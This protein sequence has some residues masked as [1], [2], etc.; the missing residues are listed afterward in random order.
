MIFQIYF[1]Q[2]LQ[3]VAQMSTILN[4]RKCSR[5]VSNHVQKEHKHELSIF[6]DI[7]VLDPRNQDDQDEH[8]V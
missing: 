8:E 4:S 5:L 6:G 1:T 2:Q 3:H 7:P